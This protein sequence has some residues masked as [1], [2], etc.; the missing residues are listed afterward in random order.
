MTFVVPFGLRN[1]LVGV[2]QRSDLR[3]MLSRW[4]IG[5]VLD[6]DESLTVSV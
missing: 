5:V 4:A 3:Y 2:S 6:V 1:G